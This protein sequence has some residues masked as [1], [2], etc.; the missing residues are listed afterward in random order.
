MNAPFGEL[1][2]GQ[3]SHALRTLWAA[4]KTVRDLEEITGLSE[5]WLYRRLRKLDIDLRRPP[6]RPLAVPEQQIVDEYNDGDSIRSLAER[7][8]S[9]YRQIRDVLVEN[10]VPLRPPGVPS[11]R[12]RTAAVNIDPMGL[13]WCSK[14][15]EMHDP[16]VCR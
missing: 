13:V 6:R 1:A 11:E 7:H 16:P 3:Q 4:G 14:C 2:H 12:S 9:Y 15:G 8:E 5:T 10:R